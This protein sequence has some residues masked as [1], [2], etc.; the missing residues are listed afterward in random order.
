[1][2]E[3]KQQAIVIGG[4]NYSDSSRV[5][6]LFTP[7]YGRQ[8][9]L[10]KG[11]RRAKSKFSGV[12]E[13]FNMLE[14]VYRRSRSG[15][16]HTLKEA[17]VL[18]QFRG[19]R[20]DLDSFMAA[21]RAVELIKDVAA[22]DQESA[23]LFQMLD[24]FL[25]C[26]DETAGEEGLAGLLLAGFRWRLVSLLG[27]EPHLTVCMSCGRGLE[28]SDVYRFQPATGGVVCNQCAGELESG[29]GHPLLLNYAA[30]RFI[31]RSCRIFPLTREELRALG[32]EELDQAGRAVDR[33]TAYHL[34]EKKTAG[35]RTDR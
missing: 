28:R 8:S 32:P 17:S 29:A 20:K 35:G 19:L 2:N 24:D 30:L 18:N 12:L 11:A 3:I 6:W 7:E 5:L 14:V 9:L 23:E 4:I 13:T 21:S 22:E 27:L 1:M 15:T 16:L 25:C 34:G 26:A 31:Y 10:V 33:Y